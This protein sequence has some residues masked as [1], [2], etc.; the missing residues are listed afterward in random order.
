VI[1]SADG[2]S[3]AAV[4]GN[5][6]KV[7]VAPGTDGCAVSPSQHFA[8]GVSGRKG[9][10]QPPFF[11]QQQP[12]SAQSAQKA[13]AATRADSSKPRTAQRINLP[14]NSQPPCH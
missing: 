7:E 6:S 10:Q 5:G 9:L 14:D 12:W 8:R 11:E 2:P 13:G 1:T 4:E 3:G